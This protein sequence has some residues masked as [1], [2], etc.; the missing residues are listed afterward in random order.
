[1]SRNI[2]SL[3]VAGVTVGVFGF[4]F[5][6]IQKPASG[7]ISKNGVLT[8]DQAEAPKFT[9][10]AA[11]V[12]TMSVP[13]IYSENVHTKGS[14]SIIEQR[15]MAAKIG[16]AESRRIS[17]TVYVATQPLSYRED[18]AYA[19]RSSKPDDYAKSTVPLGGTYYEMFAKS[20]HSEAI[21]FVPGPKNYAVVVATTSRVSYDIDKDAK[22][23]IE[24]FKWKEKQ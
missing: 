13:A 20:D 7:T 15:S 17:V 6:L 21:Y 19:F 3:V 11:D 2:K 9:E 8:A 10:L 23:A 24:S 12:F 22:V 18:S 5:Y 4:L 16:P 14:E 1:M